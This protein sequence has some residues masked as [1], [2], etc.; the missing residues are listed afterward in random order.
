MEQKYD[1]YE[2]QDVME[3]ITVTKFYEQ[4]YDDY[5]DQDVMEFF[6]SQIDVNT[7]LS[8]HK[9]VII[10]KKK[11]S[12]IKSLLVCSQYLLKEDRLITSFGVNHKQYEFTCTDDKALSIGEYCKK[13]IE[14]NPNACILLELSPWYHDLA[15]LYSGYCFG[16]NSVLEYLDIN[17]GDKRF[18]FFDM[19]EYILGYDQ[20]GELL[21]HEYNPTFLEYKYK[22]ADDIHQFFIK[23]FYTFFGLLNMYDDTLSPEENSQRFKDLFFENIKEYFDEDELGILY[24]YYDVLVSYF[25]RIS[26]KMGDDDKFDPEKYYAY[27][28]RAWSEVADFFIFLIIL[29]NKFYMDEIVVIGGSNH[30]RNIDLILTSN[31]RL[32]TP[33]KEGRDKDCVNI[34][35]KKM[36]VEDLQKKISELFP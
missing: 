4:K 25:D 33:I 19:R 18:I 34:R 14:Y 17:K 27:L 29:N 9:K 15:G 16:I 1:E 32:L 2:D 22:T 31:Y 23:P 11:P 8:E 13:V 5:A 28:F 30:I 7:P 26:K 6:M 21:D 35:Y 36:N 24:N 10:Q 3:P 12:E 20:I